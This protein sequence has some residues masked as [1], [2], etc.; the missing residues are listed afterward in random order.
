MPINHAAVVVGAGKPL[1]IIETPYPTAGPGEIVIETKA[2]AFNPADWFLAKLDMTNHPIFKLEYPFILGVDCAGTV[3]QVGSGVTTVTNGDRVIAQ[4]NGTLPQNGSRG[5]YQNY[6][7]VPEPYFGKIPDI[8]SFEKAVVLPLGMMTAARGL[9]EKDQLGMVLPPSTDGNGK[10]LLVWG[11]SSSVGVNATQLAAAAGYEV[12]SIA[13]CH[14]FDLCKSVGATQV[15][16]YNDESFIDE[17]ASSLKGKDS[18][19]AF[20]AIGTEATCKSIFEIIRNSETQKRLTSVNP[21]TESFAPD[22][23]EMT[24]ILTGSEE[25]AGIASYLFGWVAEALEQ[26]IIQSKPDP[27]ILGHGLGSVQRGIDEG[28]KGPSGKKLVVTL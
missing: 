13:S 12:I 17:V 22:D 23:F 16:D 20:N 27:T 1:E 11:G 6:V 5:G 24:C 9:F 3:V 15:F 21:G 28:L 18:V 2:A 4:A 14:N 19:G 10:T 26:G 25:W 7:V 8:L